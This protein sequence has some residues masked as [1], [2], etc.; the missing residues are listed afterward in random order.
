MRSG[1]ERRKFRF[2]QW[3]YLAH[4]RPIRFPGKVNAYRILLV[5]WTQP[6]IVGGDAAYLGNQQMRGDLVAQTPNSLQC[7]DSL[8]TRHK[9]LRLKLISGT[10]RRIDT[11]MR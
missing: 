5:T 8:R 2:D 6:Q 7:R 4:Q 11:K 1:L 9:I 3:Q 10:G